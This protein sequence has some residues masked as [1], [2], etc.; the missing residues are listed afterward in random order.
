MINRAMVREYWPNEDP[1]GKQ[2]LVPAQRV[3][4]TIVGIRMYGLHWR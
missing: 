4:A 1:L 2:V 3:P